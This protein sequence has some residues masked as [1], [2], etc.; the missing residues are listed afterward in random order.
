MDRAQTQ[1]PTTL[2]VRVATAGV[3]LEGTLAVPD[4]VQGVVLFAHG[5]GS[6]RHS[7]R[8][9]HVARVLRQAGLA[10]L[11][12]DRGAELNLRAKLPGHYEQPGEVMDCTPLG[13]AMRFPGDHPGQPENRCVAL[14]RAH[15]AR[16]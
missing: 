9:Q 12:I 2:E 5:S 8:N 14:L 7:P 11:L 13:Y 10:T 4:E 16:E 15:E 3:E 1:P 6:G